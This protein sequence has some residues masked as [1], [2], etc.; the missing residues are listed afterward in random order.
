MANNKPIFP[1][2]LK[3][4]V[5][6]SAIMIILTIVMYVLSITQSF[7][8]GLFTLLLLM[9]LFFPCVKDYRDVNGTMS[10]GQGLLV[11]IIAGVI[12]GFIVG[13]FT[14]VLYA[15][16]DPGML[17]TILETTEEQMLAWGLSE[18]QIETAMESARENTT[19]W[20]MAF[21]N[22]IS[23]PI[24]ALIGSLIASLIFKREFKEEI[25]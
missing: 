22:I 2:S 20:S 12:S 4:G 3:W 11:G 13:G 24:L 9:L 15:F 6:I 8:V 1:V 19:P 18:D 23:F 17:E 14:Y 5:I 25:F 21:N 10:F 16:I 7:V